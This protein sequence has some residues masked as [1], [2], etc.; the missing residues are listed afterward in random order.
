MATRAPSRIRRPRLASQSSAPILRSI[1]RTVVTRF[2]GVDEVVPLVRKIERRLELRCEIEQLG[3]DLGDAIGQRPFQLIE[4][5]A[6]L[7]RSD[8]VD[9]IGDGFGLH[10]ID[11]AV[12]E[13]AK[14]ELARLREPRSQRDR[15]LDDL[16]SAQP[17]F[18]AR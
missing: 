14:R 5:R 6:G 15:L 3:I 4:R 17:G 18:R 13:C 2:A 10:E 16:P 8:G 9:E 1:A 7:Q 12:E 11:P